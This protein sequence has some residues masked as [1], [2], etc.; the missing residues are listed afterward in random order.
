MTEA[1]VDAAAPAELKHQSSA[2]TGVTTAT[3]VTLTFA[4]GLGVS[5]TW[6]GTLSRDVLVLSY[7]AR[8]GTLT[9]LTFAPGTVADYNS[10]TSLASV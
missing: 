4:Q 5:T 8:D 7:P 3:S 10:R 1:F 6:T 9:T 2:F